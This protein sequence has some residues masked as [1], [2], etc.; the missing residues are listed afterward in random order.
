MHRLPVYA[1]WLLERGISMPIFAIPGPTEEVPLELAQSLG[2]ELQ[3]S[4]SLSPKC[5]FLLDAYDFDQWQGALSLMMKITNAL[6]FTTYDVGVIGILT[7]SPDW[8]REMNEMIRKMV[9]RLVES[10]VNQIICVGQRAHS[11][12]TQEITFQTA[13]LAPQLIEIAHKEVRYLAIW[14]HRD[15]NNQPHLKKA[16]WVAMQQLINH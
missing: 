5:L 2:F 16:A 14:D 12:L 3:Y 7:K 9:E 4:G 6:G 11:L 8:P 1:E 15:M 13:T 10:R